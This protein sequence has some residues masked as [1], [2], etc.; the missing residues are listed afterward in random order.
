M[1][2]PVQVLRPSDTLSEAREVM[3]TY[4]VR[5]LPIVE[6]DRLVGVVSISDLYAAEAIVEVDP[7]ETLLDQLM[8]TDLYTVEPKARLAEV[9]HV[10]AERHL[11][12]ALVVEEGRLVGIFTAVDA[13]RTLALMLRG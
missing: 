1:T 2:H 5:H 9:V 11:G 4:G 10:M 13:C 8:A 7:D 6:G 3:Q 12:S